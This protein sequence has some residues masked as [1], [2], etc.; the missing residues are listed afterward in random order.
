MSQA[1]IAN[2]EQTKLLLDIELRPLMMLLMSKPSTMSEIADQL[3]LKLNRAHYLIGKL[4][5]ANIAQIDRKEAR[6][7]RAIK[8]YYM[9]KDWFIPFE[10]T[11]E[12][13]L[14]SFVYM[15]IIPRMRQ[16]IDHAV[17]VIRR[18]NSEQL[19]YWLNGQNLSVGDRHGSFENLFMG[20]EPFFINFS[21]VRL[22]DAKAR[23]LKGRIMDIVKEYCQLESSEYPTYTLGLML[24]EGELV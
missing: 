9:A 14:E 13:S 24:V 20:E 21:P 16:L 5:R 23:E 7:G 4:E 1:H 15:Q 12:D 6:A 8:Y 11:K 3:N 2:A 22:S 18:H 10:K 17:R 19:G